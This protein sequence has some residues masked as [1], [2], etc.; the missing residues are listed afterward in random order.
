MKNIVVS[1]GDV[2]V[3]DFGGYQHW[4]IVTDTFC[5]KGLPQLISATKRNGT[6]REEPWDVVTQGKHTYVADIKYDRPVSEVLRL[7]R[8]KIGSWVYS[9]TD[10]NCEHFA[11]WATGLKVSSTQ[12]VA[13]VSGAAAGAALVGLCAENPKAAKLLGGAVVLGGLAVLAARAVEKK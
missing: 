5:S 10:N 12:V 13:G 6:V 8:S 3:S 11:K 9:L 2:V 7:S 1:A 4:S